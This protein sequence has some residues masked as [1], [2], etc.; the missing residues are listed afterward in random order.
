MADEHW[1]SADD[2]ALYKHIAMRSASATCGRAER[3][4]SGHD[5]AWVLIFNPGKHNEGV[6]TLQGQPSEPSTYVLAFEQ[7]DDAQS[8]AALLQAEGFELATPLRWD[9][10][11]L[12]EFCDAGGFEV[13]FVPQ[14]T[15]IT[16][17]TKNEYDGAFD[18]FGGRDGAF[19]GFG[20][21]DDTIPDSWRNSWGNDDMPPPRGM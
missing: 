19:G 17:P 20:G 16:P 10:P 3:V 7:T 2:S 6:Y 4:L 9:S 1:T 13:S 15:I 8:F 12:L 18:S 21:R 5:H 14:G 11:R